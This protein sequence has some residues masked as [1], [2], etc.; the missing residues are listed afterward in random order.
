MLRSLDQGIGNKSDWAAY[1]QLVQQLIG[2]P[3]RRNVFT[4]WEMRLL[5]DLQMTRMRKSSRPE[6]LR[7]YLRTVEQQAASGAAAPMRF[8]E[9]FESDPRSRRAVQ[10]SVHRVSLPRAS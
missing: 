4:P 2:G 10:P 1:C 5:L 6:V 9:F 3:V 8:S 7:R